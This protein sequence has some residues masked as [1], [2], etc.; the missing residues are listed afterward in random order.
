MP[1]DTP[2]PLGTTAVSRLSPFQPDARCRSALLCTNLRGLEHS[3]LLTP[4]LRWR[5]SYSTQPPTTAFGN[6]TPSGSTRSQHLSQG[7]SVEVDNYTNATS[8]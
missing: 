1:H 4:K 5:G 3:N 7:Y 6:T 8:D 2:L